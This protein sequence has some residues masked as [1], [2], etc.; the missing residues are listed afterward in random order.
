MGGWGLLRGIRRARRDDSIHHQGI[1]KRQRCLYLSLSLSVF[2]SEAFTFR[3][4]KH[5][6]LRRAFAVLD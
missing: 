3:I 6:Q 1:Y 5:E 4:K 2:G